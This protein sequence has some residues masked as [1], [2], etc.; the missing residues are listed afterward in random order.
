[1]SE[2]ITAG[3]KATAAIRTEHAAK[4]MTQL[5]KHFAH[6]IPVTYDADSADMTFEIGACHAT[7]KDGVLTLAVTVAAPDKLDQL[8]DV[9][10]RHLA[11]FAFREELSADWR[12]G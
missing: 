9:V 2:T 5:A 12:D 7:A 4:Y 1:M 10:F 8:K 11:R 6:K 3:T